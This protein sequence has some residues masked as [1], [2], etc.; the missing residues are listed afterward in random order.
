MPHPTVLLRAA[1]NGFVWV[2]SRI[3]HH[4]TARFPVKRSPAVSGARLPSVPP[5]SVCSNGLPPFTAGGS[6]AQLRLR[7]LLPRHAHRLGRR[8]HGQAAMGGMAIYRQVRRF[9]V[10]RTVRGTDENN[11]GTRQNQ[12]F[13]ALHWARSCEW[14]RTSTNYNPI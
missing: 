9:A 11:Q 13:R 3:R 12:A 8:R 1:S 7:R 10:Y 6:P 14:E 2:A 4:A 5:N